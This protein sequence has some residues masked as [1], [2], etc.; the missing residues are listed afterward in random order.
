MYLSGWSSEQGS[1]QVSES[2]NYSALP[3][4]VRNGGSRQVICRVVDALVAIRQI[5]ISI[6]AAWAILHPR[7][8]D[9]DPNNQETMKI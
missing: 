1:E 9:I 7:R 8:G 3:L 2:R 4:I 5:E 6:S